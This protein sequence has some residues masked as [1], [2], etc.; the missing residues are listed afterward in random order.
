MEKLFIE[1]TNNKIGYFFYIEKIFEKQSKFQNILVANTNYFGKCLFLD[2]V[3]QFSEK[4]E[5]IYHESIVQ[6]AVHL[7]T[8]PKKVLILGGGDC[9]SA[10]EFFKHDNIEKVVL[11]DI[12]PEVVE[13]SKKYFSH[14]AQGAYEDP[15][16]EIHSQDAYNYV[17]TTEEKFDIIVMDLTDPGQPIGKSFYCNE[18]FIMCKRIMNEGAIFVTHGS[19]MSVSFPTATK[20]FSS[21]KKSFKYSEM[22]TSSFI[23]SYN[24]PIG[25]LLGHDSEI[26][27]DIDK[28]ESRYLKV[29]NK[30]KYYSPKMHRVMFHRP[31][32]LSDEIKSAQPLPENYTEVQKSKFLESDFLS[33]FDE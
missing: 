16:L 15:R 14:L 23:N 5:F 32:W 2:N 10:R 28:I 9:L 29:K 27:T 24:S 33:F 13:I 18:F 12:D 21:F 30:L 7:H 4:D 6:P 31:K 1:L 22:F 26:I 25:F 8:N 3:P 20:V 17:K 19:S 11:I